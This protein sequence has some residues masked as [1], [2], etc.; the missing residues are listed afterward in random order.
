MHLRNN[1][2]YGQ[3]LLYNV[4]SLSYQRLEY[5]LQDQQQEFGSIKCSPSIIKKRM[6][7]SNRKDVNVKVFTFKKGCRAPG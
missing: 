3:N 7:L 4:N 1:E 5:N 6:C 2:D